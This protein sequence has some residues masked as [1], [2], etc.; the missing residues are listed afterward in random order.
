M[1][2][3]NTE[4]RR[5]IR[6]EASPWSF[7]E[8]VGRALWM[9][10]G[11]T[12][13][14]FT[15]HNWYGIRRLILRVFGAKVGSNVSIRPSVNIEVPWMVHIEEGATIG[16]H[17]IIYS[18]GPVHIGARAV[19]SQYAH[20]CAGTHDYSDP[21]FRLIRSPITI[22]EDVWIGADAFVGPGVTVGDLAVLGARSCAY[23]DLE[24]GR[25][26]VGNPAH[27]LKERTIN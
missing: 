24:G 27:D 4:T 17:A 6:P 23:K 3:S 7:R 8:K 20:L 9:L 14:R 22:G 18:L 13:F 1:D 11:K 5:Q 2:D 10:I 12:I 25:I 19:I 26:Y 21:T 16:D 15:F